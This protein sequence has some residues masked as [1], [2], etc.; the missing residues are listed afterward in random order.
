[1]DKYC[2]QTFIVDMDDLFMVDNNAL[3]RLC[4]DMQIL[5]SPFCSRYVTD[6]SSH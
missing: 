6:N 1:M 4:I 5:I 2:L 3:F